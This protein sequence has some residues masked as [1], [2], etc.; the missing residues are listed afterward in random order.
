MAAIT[1]AGKRALVTGAADGI[2]R[3]IVELFAEEGAR[4]I[5][6][7]IDEE[8][9]RIAHRDNQAVKTVVLDITE[10]HAAETLV[11]EATDFF[12]GLDILV[13]NAGIVG[14][15]VPLADTSDQTWDR[16]LAVN[17]TAAFKICRAFI[18]LL[19]AS[20]AGRIINTSSV[21]SEYAIATAGSYAA[22]KHAITGLT[23]ALAVELGE[24]GIT[25]NC[26]RPGSTVTGLTR[27]SLLSE[28]SP[29]GKKYLAA[30]TVMRRYGLP[31]D[32]AGAALYLA[33]DLASYVTGTSILVDGG[34]TV[35]TRDGSFWSE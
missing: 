34:L 33:S 16:V 27:D 18:P 2:G 4:V 21:V 11:S 3:G 20:G 15:F 8:R 31:R 12:G 9:L 19:K 26:I 25:A 17:V 1:L 7:D 24:F 32:L 6:V 10:V 23:R 13:N 35:T 5:A 29:E 14:E 28:D 22:S 30:T